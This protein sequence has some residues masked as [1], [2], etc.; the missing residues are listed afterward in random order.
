MPAVYPLLEKVELQIT[1]SCNMFCGFCFAHAGEK[2]FSMPTKL[3]SRVIR[4]TA[5]SKDPSANLKSLWLT[6]GEALLKPKL[7]RTLV[8]QA[9]S[10][11]LYT[12]I[13]T[14]GLLLEREASSLVHAGL[15]AVRV[16]LD[17]VQ[18]E[19]FDQL[20]GTKGGLPV[21][22]KGI[23]TAVEE[24]LQ[25]G[26]RFTVTKDNASE[27]E[28]VL[29]LAR[30]RGVSSF[31]VKAVLP[32]GRGS[33]SAMLDPISLYKVMKKAIAFSTPDMPVSV[34][35]SYLAPCKGYEVGQGH[36]PCVCATKAAYVAVDGG[37][38]PCS[39][40]PQTS[41]LNVAKNTLI[42]AWKSNDFAQARSAHFDACQPCSMWEKCRNGCPA[43]LTHYAG[44]NN[45]CFKQ[46]ETLRQKGHYDPVCSYG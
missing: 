15:K 23:E 30:E 44:Y 38:L 10:L 6:G 19:Q 24:G 35:C 31:E 7:C 41:R 21:V 32:L 46:A 33:A 11:D 40:F 37:I 2:S 26:V 43:L 18:F 36:V 25:T 42:D 34:L 8:E 20:R 29:K 3:A 4:E 45:L 5:Q 1:T 13:A 39:Y 27:L 22:L 9:T 16:S 28:D 14:N 17:S 12:G